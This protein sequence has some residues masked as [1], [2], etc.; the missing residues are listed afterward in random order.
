MIRR[1][2]IQYALVLEAVHRLGCHPTANQIYDELAT[3][4]QSISR[5]T[6]YRNLGR[7]CENGAIQ[8]REI[9]GGADRFDHI[10]TPHYHAKCIR[11]NR[12]FDV[13]MEYIADID[14]SI[15]GP[16]GFVFCGHDIVFKG[17]CSQ[18][19]DHL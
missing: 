17:V 19:K 2:T 8:R 6:V 3:Q 12:V 14:Q 7:L 1:K 16:H 11:C 13:D 4:H 5:G 18:C 15:K 10:P 9:T